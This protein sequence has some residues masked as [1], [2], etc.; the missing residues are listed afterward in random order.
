MFLIRAISFMAWAFVLKRRLIDARVHEIDQETEHHANGAETLE[1]AH[2][3]SSGFLVNLGQLLVRQ[4][5]CFSVHTVAP[6]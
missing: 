4:L 2:I 6:L 3:C 5:T 1:F